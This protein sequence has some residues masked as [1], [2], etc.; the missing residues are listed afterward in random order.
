LTASI[1]DA[2]FEPINWEALVGNNAAAQ[3]FLRRVDFCFAVFP[4]A[5]VF[6]G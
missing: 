6:F 5:I 4:T 3:R 1:A 2:M